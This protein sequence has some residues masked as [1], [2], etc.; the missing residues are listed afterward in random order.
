MTATCRDV[1]FTSE[2]T[3]TDPSAPT[4]TT[5]GSE[6]QNR[7]P[8]TNRFSA[9]RAYSC[10][11]DKPPIIA[12]VRDRRVLDALAAGAGGGWR[13]NFFHTMVFDWLVAVAVAVAVVLVV[14][15]NFRFFPMPVSPNTLSIKLVP[16]PLSPSPSPSP[17]PWS[18]RAANDA[19]HCS[20]VRAFERYDS[21]APD[22]FPCPADPQDAS[23]WVIIVRLL[24]KW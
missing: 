14:S 2:T 23:T 24:S 3:V 1:H 11:A 16:S 15:S 9:T 7:R 8:R 17:C 4:S 20:L 18:L 13:E 10:C 5:S 12:P 6:G 21:G 22:P 19:V